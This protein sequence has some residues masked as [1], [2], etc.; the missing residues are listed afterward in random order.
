MGWPTLTGTEL[1]ALVTIAQICCG[2]KERTASHNMLKKHRVL[3][4]TLAKLEKEKL[5]H[6]ATVLQQRMQPGLRARM[7][8]GF[9]I[10]FKGWTV[11]SQTMKAIG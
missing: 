2:R 5:I 10:T 4:E 3:T 9:R 6:I 1:D 7:Q 11:L 8:A